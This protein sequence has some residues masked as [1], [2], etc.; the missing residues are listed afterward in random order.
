MSIRTFAGTAILFAGLSPFAVA[1]VSASIVVGTA[2][3]PPVAVGVVGLA[4]AP[5]YVW[6]GGYWDWVGG[7]WVWV[8][9]R[10]VE[11]PRRHAVWVAPRYVPYHEHFRYYH[12]HWR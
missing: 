5:G 9:G 6:V 10:W 2:P 8:P 7:K 1:R 11:P 12:G 4:P 3:P